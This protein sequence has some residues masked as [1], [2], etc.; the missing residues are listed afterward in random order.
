MYSVPCADLANLLKLIPRAAAPLCKGHC[1]Q[2]YHRKCLF[3]AGYYYFIRQI[4]WAKQ[5]KPLLSR[6][7]LSG[8]SGHRRPYYWL[9]QRGFFLAFFWRRS[10]TRYRKE[11]ADDW[12]HYLLL[13]TEVLVEQS[14]RCTGYEYNWL[15]MQ[16]FHLAWSSLRFLVPK[17]VTHLPMLEVAIDKAL[18]SL[19]QG[20][21]RC[22]K[23]KSEKAVI[24][25]IRFSLKIPF[26]YSNLR[27]A[28]N[29][30]QDT[31]H[32]A[33]NLTYSPAS[34]T[35]FLAAPCGNCTAQSYCSPA[36]LQNDSEWI[37]SIE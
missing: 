23:L 25:G 31:P 2:H 9:H 7:Q 33:S 21:K 8:T 32:I 5:R 18:S 22:Y 35:V 30:K 3:A 34:G 10:T 14:D 4:I 19:R 6:W 11:G 15:P 26:C 27:N 28:V 16:R 13:P 37:E 29:M 12:S 36:V 17:V 20:F 1:T 24:N